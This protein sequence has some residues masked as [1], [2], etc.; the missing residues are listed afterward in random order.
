MKPTGVPLRDDCVLSDVLADRTRF[1]FRF[2][3]LNAVR[4]A[5]AASVAVFAWPFI[6]TRIKIFVTRDDMREEIGTNPKMTIKIQIQL[7]NTSI[8]ERI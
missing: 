1:T 8:F 3:R 5:S 4:D 2:G 7:K 6:E